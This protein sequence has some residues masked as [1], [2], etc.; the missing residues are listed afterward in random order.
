MSPFHR[1][2]GDAGTPPYEGRSPGFDRA[3]GWLNSPALGEDDLR[4][5]VVLTDFW[6]YTCINWLRTLGY[7]RAWADKYEDTGLL[8]VG[9]HTPEF[10]FERDVENIRCAAEQMDV[11]YPIALDPSYAVWAAFDNRY[12][13]AVYIADAEGR[14][15]HHHYGEGDYDECERVVQQLLRES[16]V[17]VSDDLVSIAPEGLEAQ[18]DWENLGSPETYLGARQG[19]RRTDAA[20]DS[21]RLNQ[22]SLSGDWTVASRASILEEGDG[23]IALRFHSRDVHLVMGS[24]EK[25]SSVPFRVL[26]D[27]APPLAAHG[28]DVDDQGHGTVAQPRLYQLIRKHGPIADSTIE[29]EFPEGG[30]EAYAFTFG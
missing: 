3:S 22:W 23:A 14:T 17:D 26:V 25:G 11:R 20:P 24:R 7:V 12:W 16:G 8:V 2:A 5:K 21:L 13:P 18:A 29:I 10:P 4:G 19:E 27:G 1:H 28:L 9:V 15:R 30:V 6:T